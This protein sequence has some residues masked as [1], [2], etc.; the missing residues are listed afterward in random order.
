[1]P[2]PALVLLS[3]AIASLPAGAARAMPPGFTDTAVYSGFAEPTTMLFAPDGRMFV[4]ERGGVVKVIENGVV[5]A[6]PVLTLAVE[7]YEEQGLLGLELHPD[8]PDSGWLYVCYTPFTGH[9]NENFNFVSRFLLTGNVA[10]PAS[11]QVLID[12]IPTG[13][14]YHVAGDIH[15]APDGN[16]FVSTGENGWG[17]NDPQLDDNLLGKLLRIRAWGGPAPGNPLIGVGGARPEIWQMGL[18]NPFRFAVHPVTGMTYVCD[19]GEIDYEEI[20][21]AGP[22]ANFGFPIYEGP[23]M[24]SPAW[25]TNPWYS[26]PHEGG[27]AL[28]GAAF[29]T[30]VVFPP[31]FWRNLFFLDHMRGHIGRVELNPDGTIGSATF[32]WGTTAVSGWLTGPIALVSGPDGALWYNTYDPGDIHRIAYQPT[33]GAGDPPGGFGLRAAVPNPF[34]EGTTIGFSVPSSGHARLRVFDLGGRVVR[35]LADG[36]FPAGPHV[37]RWDGRDPD[38][39]AAGPGI[40]FARLE[41]AGLVGTRRLVLTR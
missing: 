40:Y 32:P 36:E 22:G 31:V 8:F 29:Y 38:G 35:T 14:G 5:A 17:E 7:T 18:R 39:R 27:A 9:R 10:D 28:T 33:A 2:R 26:Y 24:N 25:H 16:L 30:G 15:F 19:V 41:A 3:V 12:D 4:G 13:L 23:V 34:R 1:M 6:T 20:N 37:V 21:V 11:E